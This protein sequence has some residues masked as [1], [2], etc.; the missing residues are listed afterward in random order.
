MSFLKIINETSLIG[1]E[2]VRVVTTDGGNIIYCSYWNGEYYRDCWEYPNN[3]DSQPCVYL[4]HGRYVYV[5]N[6]VVG[7]EHAYLYG[8]QCCLIKRP[9]NRVAQEKYNK[10]HIKPTVHTAD[11]IL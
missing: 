11:F 2:N 9:F 5:N 4:G 3:D 6:E 7:F 10:T 1:H 8:K